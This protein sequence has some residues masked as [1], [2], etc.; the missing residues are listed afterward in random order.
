M[1]SATVNGSKP[2]SF[3]LDTGY[4][5]TT[6]HPDLVEPLGLKRAS[7]ITI[8][9]IA[10]EEKA[11]TFSGVIFDF[12][13]ATYSP[14]RVASLPSDA[15]GRRRRDGILGA[16]FFRRFTVEIDSEKRKLLLH[17]PDSFRYEGNGEII[18][19]EFEADTP[20][21][22]ATIL[23]PAGVAVRG[24][25]EID[26]GCDDALCLGR[27]FVETHRLADDEKTSSG[28]KR[29]VGGSARINDG[30]VPELRLGQFTI[31]KPATSFFA[32]GSPAGDGLAGHIGIDALRHYKVIFDYARKRMILEQ[33]R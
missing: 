22:E 31:K 9:G 3:L 4:G 21:I 32:D 25:F 26:T 17:Q 33:S 6:I 27:E 11:P 1:I 8:R 10:G 18:P 16:G 29:G 2:L 14:R 19:I 7:Q 20:I 30:S 15:Q 23:S 24:R 12:G 13:S 28:I 5:I